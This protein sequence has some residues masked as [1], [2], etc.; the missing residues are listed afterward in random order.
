MTARPFLLISESAHAAMV[1]A[2]AHAYPDETGGILVGVQSGGQP[3]VTHA[4]E[5]TSPSRAHHRYEIPASTTQP[6]VREA[7][8]SDC[9]LGYLGDWHSHPT[10]VGPSPT[11]F[12]SLEL[13]SAGPRSAHPTLVVVRNTPNG[14]VLDA[15]RIVART[16]QPCEVRFAG[17]L[18]PL[19]TPE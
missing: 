10:D 14:Y 16:P 15:H 6:A 13:V 12:T 18:Q 2:A 4:V 3:W 1:A 9:R 17:N 7:R 5:I 11:D 19:T 8:R